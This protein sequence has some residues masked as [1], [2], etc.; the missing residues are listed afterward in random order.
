MSQLMTV[1]FHGNALYGA[2]QNG[3]V[4]V[5]LK[6]IV[7]A[8]GLAWQSQLQRLKRGSDFAQGITVMVI[9]T[10]QGQQSSVGLR[11]ILVHGWLFTISSPAH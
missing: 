7:E 5:A 9:P 8:M 11:L 1:N 4:F 10:S 2:N 6:P 3:D